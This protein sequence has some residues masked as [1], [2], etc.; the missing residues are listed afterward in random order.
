MDQT[1]LDAIRARCEQYT[2]LVR[3]PGATY[4]EIIKVSARIVKR[5]V[6]DLLFEHS[7]LLQKMQQL[8]ADLAAMTAERDAWRRRAECAERDISKM[9]KTMPVGMCK[10]FCK[11]AGSMCGAWADCAP[12]WRG[13]EEDKHGTA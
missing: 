11:R 4:S 8:T 10:Q 3:G 5:D 6:P 12:E 2:R 1:R 13:P 9:L 7:E